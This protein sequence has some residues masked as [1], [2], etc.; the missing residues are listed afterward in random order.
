MRKAFASIVSVVAL[1]AVLSGVA[2]AQTTPPSQPSPGQV[3]TVSNLKPFSA[4]AD[5]MSLAGY[6]RYLMHQATG[7]WVT[8]A[9][10][11]RVVKQ[12]GQ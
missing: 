9:E 6:L 5:F 1:V 7:Q 11:T 8:Y 2:L 4:E 3:P 12:Q 10:A